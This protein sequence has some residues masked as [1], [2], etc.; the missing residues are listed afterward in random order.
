MLMYLFPTQFNSCKS[1]DKRL[2]KFTSRLP[3]ILNQYFVRLKKRLEETLKVPTY[4]TQLKVPLCCSGTYQSNSGST[5]PNLPSFSCENCSS[6]N[7]Q[8]RKIEARFICCLK[9]SSS[10]LLYLQSCKVQSRLHHRPWNC[11]PDTK[12]HTLTVMLSSQFFQ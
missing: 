12:S 5:V 1:W 4:Q 8:G 10:V 2:S 9:N 11:L 6:C 3:L 7:L